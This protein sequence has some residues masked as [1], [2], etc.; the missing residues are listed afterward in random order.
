MASCG[1]RAAGC[2]HAGLLHAGIED[3]EAT[4]FVA[5]PGAAAVMGSLVTACMTWVTISG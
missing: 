3:R 4:R 2:G 1:A 5:V